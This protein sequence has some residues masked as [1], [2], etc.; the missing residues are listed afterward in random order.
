MA[1]GRARLYVES[2]SQVKKQKPK[3]NALLNAQQHLNI[4]ETVYATFSPCCT[5]L[6]CCWSGWPRARL[7]PQFFSSISH[8]WLQLRTISTPKCFCLVFTRT[9]TLDMRLQKIWW[10]PSISQV[11]FAFW[12]MLIGAKNY[13]KFNCDTHFL[14][15]FL[16]R[17]NPTKLNYVQRKYYLLFWRNIYRHIG[18]C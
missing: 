2:R 1:Q 12:L 10:L 3:M 13:K 9:E 18:P 15:H 14:T 6:W 8:H 7:R 17:K 16:N 4:G 5:L 11:F